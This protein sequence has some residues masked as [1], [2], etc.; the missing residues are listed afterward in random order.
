MVRNI[1]V[2]GARKLLEVLIMVL[3]KILVTVCLCRR[4]RMVKK[5]V[6]G[7]TRVAVWMQTRLV[8]HR[9]IKRGTVLRRD[10]VVVQEWGHQQAVQA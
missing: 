2:E 1:Y 7:R 10:Q 4:R 3:L 5:I 8:A 9:T 6:K